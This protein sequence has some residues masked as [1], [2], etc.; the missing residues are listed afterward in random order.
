MQKVSVSVKNEIS[1]TRY[2]FGLEKLMGFSKISVYLINMNCSLAFF[3]YL[4]FFMIKTPSF[5][6]K[7]FLF[8]KISP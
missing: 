6:L 3:T 4:K 7:Y 2:K 8:I 5:K 1:E